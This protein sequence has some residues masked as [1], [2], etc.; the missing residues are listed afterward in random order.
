MNIFSLPNT[1]CLKFYVF[2]IDFQILVLTLIFVGSI[3]FLNSSL[4]FPSSPFFPSQFKNEHYTFST[5][6]LS[7][8]CFGVILKQFFILFFNKII[9][10]SLEAKEI[11]EEIKS[12]IMSGRK[13]PQRNKKN[14]IENHFGKEIFFLVPNL[15]F[16]S[17]RRIYLTIALKAIFF[18][19]YIWTAFCSH[20][21]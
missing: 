6:S 17:P 12:S 21:I 18:N 19:E 10:I 7:D 4:C 5:F 2:S 13:L 20:S 9:N 15:V 16:H 8:V 14:K 3:L 11:L 1:I